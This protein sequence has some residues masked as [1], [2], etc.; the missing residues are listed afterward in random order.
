MSQEAI[1]RVPAKA[2]LSSGRQEARARLLQRPLGRMR[3]P[4]QAASGR[5]PWRR[6][7]TLN[8]DRSRARPVQ[9]SLN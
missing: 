2:A 3:S 1:E 9:P 6:S 4:R 8:D 7:R 5:E